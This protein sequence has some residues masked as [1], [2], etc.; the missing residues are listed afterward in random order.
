VT[1]SD[2]TVQA[3]NRTRQT[4]DDSL[5]CHFPWT[6]INFDQS[7]KATACCYNRTHVLGVYPQ[8]SIEEMWFGAAAEE[9]RGHL[10]RHDL[11]HGCTL[12]LEQLQSGNFQGTH[13]R[14]A[15]RFAVAGQ[16]ETWLRYRADGARRPELM[17]KVLEFEIKN[18]CNLECIMCNGHFSSLIR[19]NREHLPPLQSPYDGA[20][21]EQIVPFLSHLEEARFLGGEPFL[22]PLYYDIWERIL[23]HH[24]ELC[25]SITT[26]ATVLA[27]RVRRIVERLHCHI[28][29]SIDSI[30]RETYEA[31][32]TNA[33]YEE[34]QENLDWLH[35][36]VRRKGTSMTFAVCPMTVNWKEL[37]GLVAYCS[38]RDIR[39]FFNTVLYPYHLSLRS[40]RAAELD[41]VIEHLT[42]S[43]PDAVTEIERDNRSAV[44]DLIRQLRAW[45][46][47]Q[48]ELEN[49]AQRRPR[50]LAAR[51][52]EPSASSSVRNDLE[53]RAAD[54]NAIAATDSIA[55]RRRE[56][57][58][59]GAL[60]HF[61]RSDRGSVPAGVPPSMF[62]ALLHHVRAELERELNPTSP[63]E[64]RAVVTSNLGGAD[65]ALLSV[66][67]ELSALPIEAAVAT[68][69]RALEALYALLTSDR[70]MIAHV[71]A[72]F[73]LL[74]SRLPA[75]S[76]LVD[77]YG[78]LVM[79][80]SPLELLDSVE[81]LSLE[82][83]EAAI[84]GR[85]R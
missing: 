82:E 11:S 75:F 45:R 60:D 30:E 20:F 68:Y 5:L 39:V 24:P 8:D 61:L 66:R 34:V 42:Y 13:A 15:D 58:R 67:A 52:V 21:V 78:V 43:R 38:D 31:I 27:P 19:K 55:H 57:R 48:A 81:P 83:I 36:Q 12:C 51:S 41:R 73:A 74:R 79:Q 4:A 23:E 10:E 54:A 56:A 2:S 72:V 6:T 85:F 37:P 62:A 77:L 17:P 46:A 40:L 64:D 14:G 18:T 80:M 7:G 59:Y 9:L 16:R 32:R 71:S 1:L 53:P 84:A 33:S 22:I 70:P 47:L 28:V 26:N 50:D 25:V 63:A 44:V 76:R 65:Q 29:T 35:Q 69:T 3:Y 49:D